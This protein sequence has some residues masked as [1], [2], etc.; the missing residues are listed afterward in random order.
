MSAKFYSMLAW[1][2]AGFVAIAFLQHFGAISGATLV[3]LL[4]ILGVTV[5][6]LHGLLWE[7]HKQEEDDQE[8]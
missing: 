4:L 7:D 2:T 6:L 3:V 5:G 8:V 1:C